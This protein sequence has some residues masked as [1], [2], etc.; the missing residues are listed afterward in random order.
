MN[1][2]RLNILQMGFNI[3]N[4]AEKETVAVNVNDRLSLEIVL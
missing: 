1:T 4:R 3:L 2:N